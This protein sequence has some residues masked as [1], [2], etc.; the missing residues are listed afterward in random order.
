MSF[1]PFLESHVGLSP[2]RSLHPVRCRFARG[3]GDSAQNPPIFPKR[4][5]GS[6]TGAAQVNL[7]RQVLFFLCGPTV[8]RPAGISRQK[9][10]PRPTSGWFLGASRLRPTPECKIN[11]P[12]SREKGA[13]V[14]TLWA[15][16]RPFALARAV[17]RRA[18]IAKR[19]RHPS[20]I[21]RPLVWPTPS[22]ARV[23]AVR[24]RGEFARER[25]VFREIG[26]FA[27]RLADGFDQH[28][29]EASGGFQHIDH[30][31][32][33]LFLKEFIWVFAFGKPCD[34]RDKIRARG[35]D[36]G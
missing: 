22:A 15:F 24:A 8:L 4:F 2:L 18:P 1:W 5:L 34:A 31:L 3:R 9:P 25:L 6:S 32:A 33:T 14:P 27:K 30:A 17:A 10:S 29:I 26:T 35:G 36:R 28:F 20:P 21:A 23:L 7:G 13:L 11:I 19:P 12:R 16:F